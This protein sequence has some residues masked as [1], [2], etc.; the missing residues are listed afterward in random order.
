MASGSPCIVVFAES[1]EFRQISRFDHEVG[2]G[3]EGV[4]QF[5]DHAGEIDTWALGMV[6]AAIRAMV[7]MMDTS[8]AMVSR[9]PGVA[10]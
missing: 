4:P 9:T 6:L 10:L 2:F 5:F 7:R 8:C 3:F 1:F